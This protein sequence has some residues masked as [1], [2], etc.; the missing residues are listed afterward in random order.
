MQM[1]DVTLS[2]APLDF[3]A[4]DIHLL[5]ILTPMTYDIRIIGWGN[6]LLYVIREHGSFSL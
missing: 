1:P 2:V 5:T 3:L 4:D 6:Y